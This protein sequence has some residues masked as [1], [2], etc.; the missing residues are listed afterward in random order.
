MFGTEES[1]DIGADEEDDVFEGAD[2]GILITR[3]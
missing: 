3:P 2:V 1:R